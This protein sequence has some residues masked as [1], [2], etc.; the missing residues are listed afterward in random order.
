AMPINN[1]KGSYEASA[2]YDNTTRNGLVVGSV[3]HDTWKT[4]VYFQGSN[5]R[6]NVL[7]VYGGVTSSDTRDVDA[8]GLV[9]GSTISSPTIYVG[10]NADWRPALEAYADANAA[11]VPRLAWNEGVPF[12]WN[13]WYA[14]GANL[15]Y[16]NAIAVSSFIKA[17]LQ[18]NQFKSHGT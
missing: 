3:T 16:S 4:G 9:K 13:S 17:N 12:G 15:S 11:M 18:T 2:F 8:H 14:Y 10:F 5:N 6:L 1:T 7:N